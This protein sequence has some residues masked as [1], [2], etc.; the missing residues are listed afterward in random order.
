MPLA[1]G[2]RG[3]HLEGHR[4][5]A[6]TQRLAQPA[7]LRRQAADAGN[8][9]VEA[10]R[11]ERARCE[12]LRKHP[13]PFGVGDGAL[14][15]KVLSEVD[16]VPRISLGPLVNEVHEA[17]QVLDVAEDGAKELGGLF[18]R[19]RLKDQPGRVLAQRLDG[20]REPG[21]VRA[22]GRHHEQPVVPGFSSERGEPRRRRL[23]ERLQIVCDDDQRVLARDGEEPVSERGLNAH[24]RLA[25]G[26]RHLR[27]VVDGE[28][29]PRADRRRDVP[30]RACVRRGRGERC[31]GQRGEQAKGELVRRSMRVAVSLGVCLQ[32]D[33]AGEPGVERELS[34]QTRPTEPRS[35]LHDRV[36]GASGG[37]RCQ[38]REQGGSL[39]GAP[40]EGRAAQVALE[41]ARLRVGFERDDDAQSIDDVCSGGRSCQRVVVEE[42]VHERFESRRHLRQVFA[43]EFRDSL[44]HEAGSFRPDRLEVRE[45][46][47]RKGVAPRQEEVREGAERIEVR[48]L[49]EIEAAKC[50]GSDEGGRTGDVG[51]RAEG[52]HR[53]EVDE[54]RSPLRR[55]PCVASA[56]VSVQEAARVEQGEPGGD[57]TQD[58]AHVA[59]RHR[60]ELR[61]V[62][63][64]EQLHGVEGPPRVRPVLVD[65]DEARMTQA[66]ERVV[67]ALEERD[68]VRVGRS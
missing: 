56:D 64:V 31:H 26:V 2:Q 36:R 18:E 48:S 4:S 47:C 45:G 61:D 41:G 35:A 29:E 43:F 16:R 68:M 17:R 38:C 57:V 67:F 46:A 12:R 49:V 32:H 20:E 25:V 44:R 54:L 5:L 8:L 55:A 66:R 58:P 11:Q 15:A 50:L 9:G 10:I 23:V 33:R 1:V 63:A 34:Q 59:P 51:R 19:E 37:A 7:C 27:E 60:R 39:G 52:G 13:R 62:A 40:D 14:A 21:T 22:E 6:Q 3:A 42:G 65:L 30:E 28:P 53:P 24:A